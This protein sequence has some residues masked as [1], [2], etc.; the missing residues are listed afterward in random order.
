MTGAYSKSGT[1]RDPDARI[2]HTSIVEFTVLTL[3]HSHIKEL[4]EQIQMRITNLRSF[5]SGSFACNLVFVKVLETPS[6]K[7]YIYTSARMRRVV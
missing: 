5:R 4:T 7:Y 3:D 2:E 6:S 1:R